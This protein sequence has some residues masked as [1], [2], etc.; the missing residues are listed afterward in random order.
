IQ[1]RS[2]TV[3]HTES[4]PIL[5]PGKTH[6]DT[7]KPSVDIAILPSGLG[8]TAASSEVKYLF[9]RFFLNTFSISSLVLLPPLPCASVT[10]SLIICLHI[11]K[12][13]NMRLRQIPYKRLQ[14]APDCTPCRK[15]DSPPVLFCPEELLRICMPSYIPF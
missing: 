9:P 5:P 1:A 6:G 11:N 2:F 7:I 8:R 13:L 12:T 15:A 10:I 14:G 4:L 3:P